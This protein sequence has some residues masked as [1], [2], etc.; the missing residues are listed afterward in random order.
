[1]TPLAPW[2]ERLHPRT[3]RLAR[4]MLRLGLGGLALLILLY[5]LSLVVFAHIDTYR[6]ALEQRLAAT[7][8]APVRIGR[9]EAE[10]LGLKPDF[11][12]RDV[13]I[14]DPLRPRQ[15]ALNLPFVGVSLSLRASLLALSPRLAVRFER[16]ALTLEELPSGGWRI[17]ELAALPEGS[18]E[19]RR[20]ALEWGLQQGE[21]KAE[22]LGLHVI[23][24]QGP[25]FRLTSLTITNRNGRQGHRLRLSGQLAGRGP[26]TVMADMTAKQIHTLSGW[27]GK[28][29][30]SLPEGEWADWLPLPPDRLRISRLRAG[31]EFW[32][33]GLEG[34]VTSVQASLHGVTAQA[35]HDGFPLQVTDFRGDFSGR[36]SAGGWEFS[37]LPHG[38]QVNGVP[39]PFRTLI[40]QRQTDGW[41]ITTQA[42][43]LES[44]ALLLARLPLRDINIALL[45]RL[46]PTGYISSLTAAFKPAP[47]WSLT[48]LAADVRQAA[49]QA[50]D[51]IPGV[52]GLSGWVRWRDGKG[53]AG[54]RIHQGVLDLKPVFREPTP[55]DALEARFRL[56]Q[57]PDSW[58]LQSDRITLK[59]A[60]AGG[61]ASLSAWIPRRDPSRARLQLLAGIRDGRVDSAW[62]YV[63]WPS[64]GDETLD[65]LRRALR[66]GRLVQGQFLYEGPLVDRP[67]DI[68]SRMQMRFDLEDATLAYAP[69]W[70]EI[71]RLKAVVTLNN[72]QL[73]VHATQGQLYESIA[74]NVVAE[75][76]EL[77]QPVL[78]VRADIDSTGE[79][80]FR[81]F[82]ETPLREDAGRMASLLAL[83]GEV[84]GSLT[85]EMPLADPSRV[86]V[87]VDAE[88]PGNPVV[89]QAADK[90]DLWLSGMVRYETGKGLT[91]KPLAG[92]LLGQPVAVKFHSVMDDQ[93]VVAV[94]VEADGQITP[95]SIRPWVG[96]LANHMRG[97]SRFRAFLAVPVE[98]APVHLTV[99][100]DLAG[101]A[102]D[103][104]SPLGKSAAA[105]PLHFEIQ[106]G[107]DE[108]LAMLRLEKRLQSLFAVQNSRITRALLQMGD[109]RLGEL[110]PKGLWVRGKL[111]NVNVDDWLPWLRPRGGHHEVGQGVFP[112]LQSFNLSVGELLAGGYRLDK[113][114]LGGEPDEDAEGRWRFQ[115][116]SDKIAGEARVPVRGNGPISLTL[117]RLVL[118]LPPSTNG[119]S[120]QGAPSGWEIPAV[121]VDIRGLTYAA[122]PGLGP[123]TLTAMLR[124]TAEGLRLDNIWLKQS[125]VTVGGRL[126]WRFRQQAESTS[127]RGTVKTG[128]IAKL[129]SAFDYPP[130]LNSEQGQASVDLSWKGGPGDLA[131]ANLQGTVDSRL[132][133]GRILKLNRTVSLSRLFGLLDTDNIK[134]RLQLD[135]SDITRKG[136]AFDEL[137]LQA[138]FNNGSLLDEVSMASPSMT[139]RGGGRVD[140]VTTQLD[141]QVQIAVPVA[142][143]APLAVAVVAGPIVG[144]A[145]VAAES[146]FD[147]SLRKMTAFNYRVS[148]PWDNPQI[149]RNKRN[150]VPWRLPG[151]KTTNGK[152][153][154]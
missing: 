143:V 114:R 63:P 102:M 136:M 153:K 19:S 64:A 151:S 122:W 119:A 138:R 145:L 25:D 66:A 20:R 148:G 70:P 76:P 30:L 83:K 7:L 98:D 65:W 139:I 14:H 21:W 115:I 18:P 127:F 2:L 58:L 147:E 82:R 31:G 95:A 40:V 52:A 17:R 62:R 69:G 29:Y 26:V 125:A 46:R 72:R 43:H 3:H 110:P 22:S 8:G 121:N 130:I 75:I 144:G 88:L 118:P 85:M 128:D 101:W 53:L 49:W 57:R 28:A 47:G 50:T 61:E 10:W 142:S 133:K 141:Q 74:R 42:L 48:E 6:P 13:R 24:R 15:V 124:P 97:S 109:G 92:F 11:R 39:L 79:D 113:V 81:L 111:D 112:D 1:M 37:S 80:L 93:D 120:G 33:E 107:A 68:P 90:F 129:F 99:D 140:L 84:G 34:R 116:E 55:V 87:A 73:Q 135:F 59:N 150:W 86:R 38:G 91:S 44:L 104:P 78:K 71:S 132:E 134:R 105:L 60:D 96:S 67:D 146:F 23:P 126:D 45:Q 27:S 4:W 56:E 51:E 12:I 108:N 35:E 123:G 16:V 103:L 89:L 32:L 9:L 36:L 131:L 149:E 77:R 152:R 5:L 54:L 94:Q 137:Q 100:S 117:Y 41:K 106:L 154:P